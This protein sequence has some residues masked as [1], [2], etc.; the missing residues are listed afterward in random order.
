MLR[1]SK[2][3]DISTKFCF[4]VDGLDEYEGDH[5]DIIQIMD[6]LSASTKMKICVSSRPWSIFFR[7]IRLWVSHLNL[8]R[9]DSWRCGTLRSK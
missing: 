2:Q 7:C 9:F 3:N 4:F 8:A 5:R 1:L 6:V